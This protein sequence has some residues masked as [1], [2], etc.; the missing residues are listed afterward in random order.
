MLNLHLTTLNTVASKALAD[1]ADHPRWINAIGRAMVELTTNPW[2]ERSAEGHGLIIGSTSGKCYTSNGVCQ[3]EAYT[4]GKKPCYHRAAARL[5]RLHDEAIERTQATI[6]T[7]RAEA[8]RA[9]T[10]LMN[11]LY[12]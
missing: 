5:V 8:A 12:A 6:R 4:H 9:A 7:N 10:A 2:I 3:C 1:A 11:E